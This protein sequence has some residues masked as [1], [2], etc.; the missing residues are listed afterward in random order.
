VVLNKMNR[1]FAKILREI[2]DICKK[3]TDYKLE[4]IEYIED[5]K[6]SGR[7]NTLSNAVYKKYKLDVEKYNTDELYYEI[8]L[9]TKT[10]FQEEL[11]KL[12]K[13]TAIYMVVFNVYD[14]DTNQLYGEVKEIYNEYTDIQVSKPSV[15]VLLVNNEEVNQIYGDYTQYNADELL[16]KKY[17][18]A[19]NFL[20][21]ELLSI[22]F[23]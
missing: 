7:W 21:G 16:L 3:G 5:F 10:Y 13:E 2:D 11:T 15:G 22:I 20:R 23:E 9:L 12:L 17:E 8:M 4:F 18:I 1:E 19:F 14:I 6:S